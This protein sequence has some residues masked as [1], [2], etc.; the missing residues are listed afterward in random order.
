MKGTFFVYP[1]D[2]RRQDNVVTVTV[3][4]Q[5]VTLKQHGD[6]IVLDEKQ[7]KQL[8]RELIGEFK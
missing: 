4:D 7:T 5:G 2:S 6:I 8:A 3:G 1:E